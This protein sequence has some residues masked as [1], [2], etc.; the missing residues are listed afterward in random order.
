[1]IRFQGLNGACHG[2]PL[3][4]QCH[5]GL[6]GRLEREWRWQRAL[7][8]TWLPFLVTS[9]ELLRLDGWQQSVEQPRAVGSCLYTNPAQRGHILS[10]KV[11]VVAADCV[12][13]G[14]SPTTLVIGCGGAWSGIRRSPLPLAK[15]VTAMSLRPLCPTTAPC[16]TT[17]RLPLRLAAR[18]CSVLATQWQRGFDTLQWAGMVACGIH[19]CCDAWRARPLRICS[20]ASLAPCAHA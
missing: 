12:A 19:A 9:F 5:T 7:P 13:E 10:L 2:A 16:R 4:A 3:C 1:M 6:L 15:L 17:G 8:S 11:S 18:G 20:C 14:G